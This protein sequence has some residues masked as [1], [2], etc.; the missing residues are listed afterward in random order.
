MALTTVRGT[1]FLAAC[2]HGFAAFDRHFFE[3]VI[4]ACKFLGHKEN[5]ANIHY[6][7]AVLRDVVIV[8]AAQPFVI[9]IKGEADDFAASVQN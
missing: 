6:E 7:T 3:Q 1:D 2:G 5:V 9:A 4:S 8:I